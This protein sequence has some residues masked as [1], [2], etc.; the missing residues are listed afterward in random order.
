MN[1]R[2]KKLYV[3]RRGLQ[4]GGAS[5]NRA[6]LRPVKK[7]ICSPFMWLTEFLSY[8]SKEAATVAQL[9][10]E[11]KKREGSSVHHP[12]KSTGPTNDP[13]EAI[14]ILARTI[15]LMKNSVVS[16]NTLFKVC[17]LKRKFYLTLLFKD[18][19]IIHQ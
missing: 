14:S 8:P 18:L 15:Y 5:L 10:E 1:I 19:M 11:E 3:K 17:F 9:P 4:I 12:E 6:W 16:Q 7:L 13:R 2:E